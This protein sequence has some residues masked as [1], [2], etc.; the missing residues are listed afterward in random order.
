MNIRSFAVISVV[1]LSSFGALAVTR[2]NMITGTVINPAVTTALSSNP[3]LPVQAAFEDLATVS[4]P[5][6][7]VVA[8]SINH[9]IVGT[10]P[11]TDLTG[12]PHHSGTDYTVGNGDNSLTGSFAHASSQLAL[13]SQASASTDSHL[14]VTG[15]AVKSI[16]DDSMMVIHLQPLPQNDNLAMLLSGLVLMGSIAVRRNKTQSS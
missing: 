4:L 1:V 14:K 12:A 15:R 2:M 9:S 10:G 13:A 11:R 16:G 3:A 8:F 6:N 7:S 5:V